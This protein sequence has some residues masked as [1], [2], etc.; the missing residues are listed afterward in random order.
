MAME[1]KNG[2]YAY[3]TCLEADGNHYKFY[4][5]KQNGNMFDVKYGR[6][7]GNK[8]AEDSFPMEKW[9]STYKTRIKHG[10]ADKTEW[11]IETIS[12]ISPSD[13]ISTINNTEV[14]DVIALLLRL[15]KERVEATYDIN[16]NKV[17]RNMIT[18]AQESLNALTNLIGLNCDINSVNEIYK[19]LLQAIP[20][21]IRK[22]VD[23][24]FKPIYNK[25]DLEEAQKKLSEEQS[26]L[27]ALESQIPKASTINET[28]DQNLSGN[29]LDQNGL[30]L[31]PCNYDEI[32]LIKSKMGDDAFRFYRAF[33][34]KNT[35]TENRFNKHINKVSNTKTELL[36]HGSRNENWWGISKIGLCI[37]P[38]NAISTGSMLGDGIYFASLFKKSLGYTSY[39]GAC[40]TNGSQ[41]FGFLALFEVHIGNQLIADEAKDFTKS[42]INKKGYDSVFG[43]ANY[44]KKSSYGYSTLYNDEYVIYAK[45]QC[46][47]KYLVQIK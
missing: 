14:R 4:E 12:S 34:I 40:W 28:S 13:P 10:Y 11:K 25:A 38:T 21:K 18:A 8:P 43:K 19:Q 26:M 5:M 36:W 42:E 23:V 31:I 20:R 46:T 33:K 15:A 29:I 30:E 27:D 6:I 3:F 1:T 22:V 2:K 45:D 35:E 24:L 32:K 37:R 7:G 9:N 41:K 17:T 16:S 39:E 44:T 47:I